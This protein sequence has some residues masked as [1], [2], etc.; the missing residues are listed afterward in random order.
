MV[1]VES[2]CHLYSEDD[3]RYPPGSDKPYRPPPGAGTVA[4][5]EQ[6]RRLVGITHAV[7]VQTHSY[8]R[9]DNRLMAD[10]V[11]ANGEWMVGV[12]NVP[13]DGAGSPDEL[14]RLAA[15]GVRGLRLEYPPGGGT[16]YHPGSVALCA[17]ARDL[18]LVVNIHASG[19]DHYGDVARLLTEFPEL[20][21][22]LDHCGY[23]KPEAPAVLENVL[24]LVGHAR[25]HMKLS[26]WA[27]ADPQYV[28]I[29]RQILA[30]YGPDR[31]MWGG[32]FPAELWHP[33]LS[34]AG[35][36]A[37][38][39]DEICQT[40]AQRQAVLGETPLRVWFPQQA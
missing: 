40:E 36:L 24:A 8:Y 21:F 25:L 23:A 35:H 14:E 7:A 10:A 22:C 32:N 26:F 37:V 12:C 19:T 15:G 34:Y 38:L 20:T 33:K 9:C 18:G 30:A 4:H 17:R 39:R 5:L 31:C 16:F 2:H 28:A 6:M 27:E 3:D 11:A 13:S 29:G 1:L